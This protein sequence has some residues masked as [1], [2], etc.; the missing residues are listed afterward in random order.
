M[1]KTNHQWI[2]GPRHRLAAFI[3]SI[4]VCCIG[5]FEENKGDRLGSQANNSAGKG[6]DSGGVIR[7]R[8]P[9]EFSTSKLDSLYT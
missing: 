6:R 8:E 2:L 7:G 9:L 5:W 4:A 1:N 3:C